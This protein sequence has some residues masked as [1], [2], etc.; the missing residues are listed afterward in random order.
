LALCAGP[1]ALVL[2]VFQPKAP[3]GIKPV[4]ANLRRYRGGF[5][6]IID[7]Q[8]RRVP[9]PPPGH[10]GVEI[11][12]PSKQMREGF[13]AGRIVLVGRTDWDNL[14]V[15]ALGGGLSAGRGTESEGLP[16]LPRGPQ[17]RQPRHSTRRICPNRRA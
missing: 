8:V 15:C 9:N 17:N 14:T 5:L 2:N 12:A 4:A 11:I 7:V 16:R 3:I 6:P 1:D 13:R 10:S